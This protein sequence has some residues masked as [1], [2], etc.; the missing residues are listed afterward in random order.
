MHHPGASAPREGGGVS[1][2]VMPR[3]KRGIQYAVT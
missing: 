2:N 3:F 1:L